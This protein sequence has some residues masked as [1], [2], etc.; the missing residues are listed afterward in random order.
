MFKFDSPMYSHSRRAATLP[1]SGRTAVRGD[2]SML[3]D[4]FYYYSKS[5]DFNDNDNAYILQPNGTYN[6]RERA[7]SYHDEPDSAYNSDSYNHKGTSPEPYDNRK[8]SMSDHEL[9]QARI[10]RGRSLPYLNGPPKPELTVA[11]ISD[12]EL[13]ER[14]QS[15]KAEKDQHNKGLSY[16][17]SDMNKGV[18]YAEYDSKRPFYG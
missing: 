8:N 15:S 7:K 9:R 2:N 4:S 6:P 5:T 1:A 18:I 17:R 11:K 13:L 3:N 12:V 10:A 14:L 16:L